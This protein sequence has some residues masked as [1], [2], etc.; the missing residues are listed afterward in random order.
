MPKLGG[1]CCLNGGIPIYLFSKTDFEK[2]KTEGQV[3]IASPLVSRKIALL[4]D[5]KDVKL[6]IPKLNKFVEHEV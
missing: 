1:F 2:L 6:I 5:K 3:N 4:L